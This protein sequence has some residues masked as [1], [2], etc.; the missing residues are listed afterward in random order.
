MQQGSMSGSQNCNQT[1]VYSSA[2]G[3]WTTGDSLSAL[4][5]TKLNRDQNEPDSDSESTSKRSVISKSR[6]PAKRK[7]KAIARKAR[8]S[9]SNKSLKVKVVS[10]H[11]LKD[12]SLF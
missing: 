3:F 12:K 10:S 8:K 4:P 1:P 2:Y 5:M 7:N 9:S 6:M 11:P